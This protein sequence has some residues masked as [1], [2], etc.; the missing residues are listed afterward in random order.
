MRFQDV[1]MILYINDQEDQTVLTKKREIK[2]PYY[3]LFQKKKTA[4][5]QALS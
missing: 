4:I 2:Q 3:K 5:L 1:T